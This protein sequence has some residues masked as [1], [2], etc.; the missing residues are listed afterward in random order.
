MIII[1]AHPNR[2][3]HNGEILQ[4]TE[5]ILKSKKIKYT[6]W[7]LYDMNF[8][9]VLK[10]DEL[11]TH[12]KNN[13]KT[14]ILKLQDKI[15]KA[16]KFMFIYP[17]WWNNTP[18][19]LKGFFDRVFIADFAFKYVRGV[20]IRLLKAKASIITTT[21]APSLISM[22]QRN[23]SINVVKNDILRF[24]GIVAKA[25]RVDLARQLNDRQKE[26]IKIQVIKAIKNLI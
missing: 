7:D 21:G 10:D 22:L 13:V 6:L 26:K 24:C 8:D 20:P 19:I 11:Y 17:T 3:S 25:Y 9:P 23:R 1:Y 14:D 18:A 16:K 4:Q 2:D 12:K 5:K 15:K